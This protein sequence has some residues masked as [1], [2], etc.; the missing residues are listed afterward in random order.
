MQR[1][2]RRRAI[3]RELR[4]GKAAKEMSGAHLAVRAAQKSIGL[5]TDAH[6]S[7][8]ISLLVP[9]SKCGNWQVRRLA[10]IEYALHHLANLRCRGIRVA[11]AT[12]LIA[13]QL[14]GRHLC[15]GKRLRASRKSVERW[16]YAWRLTRDASTL[17]L[18]YRHV[19]SYQAALQRQLSRIWNSSPEL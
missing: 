2:C 4:T 12:A 18:K 13:H 5:T 3:D 15:S 17:R 11:H 9:R 16:W 19:S 10:E 7:A 14:N 1:H 8:T 6:S